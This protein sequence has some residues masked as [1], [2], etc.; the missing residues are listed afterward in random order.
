V[1]PD[2]AL[3]RAREKGI[4]LIADPIFQ[5][6]FSG[7][8]RLKECRNDYVYTYIMGGKNEFVQ[9][10]V[11]YISKGYNRVVLGSI[12][13]I[14]TEKAKKVD[15]KMI[16]D[17]LCFYN[18]YTKSR[19]RK[20]V[21]EGSPAGRQNAVYQYIR[22]HEYWA[23][24]AT[25]GIDIDTFDTLK[26]VDVRKKG[27]DVFGYHIY[28]GKKVNV[29]INAGIY[30]EI[31][32]WWAVNATKLRQDEIHERLRENT[33]KVFLTYG[34]VK[35][36]IFTL[37]KWINH[38][39]HKQGKDP[40]TVTI[41]SRRAFKV[42]DK[43]FINVMI[44]VDSDTDDFSIESGIWYSEDENFWL[45][46]VDEDERKR[47]AHAEVKREKEAVNREIRELKEKR[48][49]TGAEGVPVRRKDI[50]RERKIAKRQAE[51][52]EQMRREAERQQEEKAGNDEPFFW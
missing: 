27:I 47:L 21:P 33:W 44:Y 41:P 16:L 10:L 31:K 37:V 9:Q 29:T 7:G 40:I 13:H 46:L 48:K 5:I 30:E 20:D 43:S 11:L 1:D 19:M 36:Q 14:T 6:F 3:K 15:R 49:G 23:V 12:R 28:V 2:R 8:C 34:G 25:D 38:H 24:V 50:K 32:A 51:L 42:Y 17:Y 39:R 26:P 22:Y 52:Q 45:N 4:G 18:K 35:K